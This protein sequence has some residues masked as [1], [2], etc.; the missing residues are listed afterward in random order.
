MDCHQARAAILARHPAVP[1]ARPDLPA[2][3]PAA[4][5]AAVLGPYGPDGSHNGGGIEGV[6]IG[7]GAY[8]D[9]WGCLADADR[10]VYGEVTNPAPSRRWVIEQYLQYAEPMVGR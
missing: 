5:A 9:P 6:M 3:E 1:S 2:S 4:A 8:N 7:R 10:A